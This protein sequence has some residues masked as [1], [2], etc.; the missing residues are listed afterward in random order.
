MS[1]VATLFYICVII[2]EYST[3]V[4]V[5]WISIQAKYNHPIKEN[6]GIPNLKI[7]Q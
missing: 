5:C 7:A 6:I 1:L 2:Q 4:H 3:T